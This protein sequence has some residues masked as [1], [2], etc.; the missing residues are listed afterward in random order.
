MQGIKI[1]RQ[2]LDRALR[3][4]GMTTLACR[5]D[6][7]RHGRYA[8]PH[9]ETICD[10]EERLRR[11][12][13]DT[14]KIFTQFARHLIR[15]N[16]RT[17]VRH[18]AHDR[19][20]RTGFDAVAA[21]RTSL[22]KHHF[23]DRPGRTQPIRPYRSRRLLT[24]CVLVSGKLSSRLSHR[25]DGVFQKISTPVFRITGHNSL[26]LHHTIGAQLV[27]FHATIAGAILDIPTRMILADEI[28][29]VPFQFGVHIL[30]P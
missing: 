9:V 24:G 17:A 7:V 23:I 16:Y 20:G 21:A 4:A 13:C 1:H 26:R 29:D 27:H 8:H 25:D 18:I 14:G 12:S 30:H 10:W 11:T 6:A 28:Q 2:R 19:P 5:A 3:H 22:E 15:K